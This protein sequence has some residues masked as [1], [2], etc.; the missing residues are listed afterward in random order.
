MEEMIRDTTPNNNDQNVYDSE[1]EDSYMQDVVPLGTGVAGSAVSSTLPYSRATVEKFIDSLQ[2]NL[3]FNVGFDIIVTNPDDEKSCFCPCSRYMTRWRENFKITYLMEKDKCTYHRR[4][5][6]KGLM[7][8]LRKLGQEEGCYMH[9]GIELY[10]K[11]LYENYWGN[12]GHKALYNGEDAM[13]RQ[14]IAAETKF[15]LA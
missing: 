13:Y 3:I 10:I 14:A 1:S 9:R 4:A 8:H 11:N 6:P 5:T 7:D 15:K 12:V 2:Y